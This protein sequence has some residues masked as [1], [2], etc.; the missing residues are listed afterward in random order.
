MPTRTVRARPLHASR[1]SLEAPVPVERRP[2]RAL[3]AITVLP[4]SALLRRAPVSALAAD[5]IGTLTDDTGAPEL[6]KEGTRFSMDS[7]CL[8]P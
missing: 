1:A 4:D 7:V 8:A 6:T 3:P 5:P 2:A